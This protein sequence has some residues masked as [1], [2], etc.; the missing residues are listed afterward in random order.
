VL[1][2][3]EEPAGRM[4]DRAVVVEHSRMFGRI[5]LRRPLAPRPG[6]GRQVAGRPSAAAAGLMAE[7][8]ALAAVHVGQEVDEPVSARGVV[9]LLAAKIRLVSRRTQHARQGRI[10][11]RRQ[12]ARIAPRTASADV[13]ARREAQPARRA[14]RRVA[15]AG[16]KR[17][18]ALGQA[19]QRGRRAQGIAIAAHVR[20]I[21]LVRHDQQDVRAIGHRRSLYSIAPGADRSLIVEQL[22]RL[23]ALAFEHLQARPAA[24]GDV[25]D[26]VGIAELLDRRR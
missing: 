15:V 23:K 7:V 21:M 25:A 6:V 24:G 3:G 1:P 11:I 9:M 5:E 8:G 14:K 16:V 18:P 22:D 2:P 19:V 4:R 20:C 13:L 10:R 26:L 12:P 17:H